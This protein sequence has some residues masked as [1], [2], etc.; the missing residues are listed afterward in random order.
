M[1]QC[2]WAVS[3][4]RLQILFT[5]VKKLGRQILEDENNALSPN[6]GK[7]YIRMWRQIAD[8]QIS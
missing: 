2:Q 3:F 1:M 4:P 8:R 5:V 7:C 6:N